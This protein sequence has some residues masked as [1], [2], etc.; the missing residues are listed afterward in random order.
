MTEQWQVRYRHRE[1]GATNTGYSPLGDDCGWIYEGAYEDCSA[2]DPVT[3]RLARELAG[4]QASISRLLGCLESTPPPVE[5]PPVPAPTTIWAR[6]ISADATLIAA[7][8]RPV[9]G[10]GV[11]EEI[12]IES[13]AAPLTSIYRNLDGWKRVNGARC[14]KGTGEI[15]A[16]LP[17]PPNLVV[18]GCTTNSTPNH[19]AAIFDANGDRWEGN[20]FARCT[21]GGHATVKQ[22]TNRGNDPIIG[23]HG[24]SLITAYHGSIRLGEWVPGK[25]VI[26]HAIKL[27]VDGENLSQAEGGFRY[28]ASKADTGYDNPASGNYYGG[29]IEALRMGSLLCL[30]TPFTFSLNTEPARILARTLQEYGGYVV[31]VHTWPWLSICTERSSTGHVRDEFEQVWGFPLQ[32]RAGQW[33]DDVRTILA[34]LRVSR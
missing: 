23:N 16:R 31:D 14:G 8:I 28:P 2:N 21:A 17:I 10:V 24:G 12:I 20:P 9:N 18:E 33:A 30:P 3:D 34:N 26:P 15:L 7:D 4:V 27:T 5:P 6:P 1:E 32:A 11:D 29:S 13:P 19:A 25:T 22:I